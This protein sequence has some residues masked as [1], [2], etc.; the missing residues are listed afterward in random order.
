MTDIDEYGFELATLYGFA[1][2]AAANPAAKVKLWDQHSQGDAQPAGTVGIYIDTS[3]PDVDAV[4]L[5]DYTV[6]DEPTTSDS[7]QGVQVVIKASSPATVKGIVSDLYDLF[8]GR[9]AGM[10]GDVTLVAS[11]RSSGTNTGQDQSGRMT[12][13]ENYYLTVWRPSP[14]RQ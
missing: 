4:Q 1:A 14:N 8:H 11:F 5:V 10:I 7:T 13:T 12:R 2:V 9:D 6:S 3:P